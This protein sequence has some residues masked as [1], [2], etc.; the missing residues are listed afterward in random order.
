MHQRLGCLLIGMALRRLRGLAVGE[1]KGVF[2][3]SK[4]I[5]NIPT[6]GRIC[7]GKGVMLISSNDGYRLRWW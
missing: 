2:F 4:P 7:I 3:Q 6:A 5:V 1:V